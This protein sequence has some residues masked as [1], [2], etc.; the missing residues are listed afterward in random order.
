MSALPLPQSA[1]DGRARA[2]GSIIPVQ[3]IAG[4]S[5]MAVVAIMTF[6]AALTGGGV[7]LIATAA[8]GWKADVSQEVTIQI[9]SAAGRDEEADVATAAQIARE[10]EGVADVKAFSK[11]ETQAMLEP[12]LGTGLDLGGLPIPRLVAVK[13]SPGGTADLAELRARLKEALPQA[14]L[15][16][17]QM[18]NA[19][20][21]KMAQS[22]IWIGIGL[23]ALMIAATA[24][25]VV[26]STRG[27][28]AGNRDVVEVLHF[29]GAH[30]TFIASE[31]QR[32]FM[33][34][35]LKGGVAG[36]ILSAVFFIAIRTLAANFERTAGGEQF[37]ALFGA[38]A[39][40]WQ[41]Y[42]I[43]MGIVLLV[44]LVAGLT[45]RLTVLNVLREHEE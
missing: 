32:H 14:E 15:E 43:I 39:L 42:V 29:I 37:K 23:L 36:G 30:D 38:F 28:M 12:W 3:S 45:S 18:W 10:A 9:R 20:L 16:D 1:D 26:F 4:R 6:L 22:T 40:G 21:A 31:F 41:G 7:H 2:S 5:L 8:A 25:S 24:L 13:L 19:R 33:L 44:A 34:L 27:A 17:H 11:S 35:G